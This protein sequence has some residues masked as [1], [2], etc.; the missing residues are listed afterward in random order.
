MSMSIQADSLQVDRLLKRGEERLREYA[1]PD[2]YIGKAS[3][4]PLA[5]EMLTA[6]S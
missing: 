1:H 2:P 3:I 5:E 6:A 4:L